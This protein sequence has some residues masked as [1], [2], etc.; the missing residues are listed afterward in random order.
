MSD[1]N[2][3]L[4]KS[5]FFLLSKTFFYTFKVF[6]KFF[7]IQLYTNFNFMK[8]GVKFLSNNLRNIEKNLRAFAKRSKS[9]KFSSEMLLAF[10]ISGVSG[11]AAKKSVSS[12]SSTEGAMSW[13]K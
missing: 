7:M 10:L 5:D 13:E 3:T 1:F 6:T 12:D 2:K 4:L 9:I 8:E 11:F